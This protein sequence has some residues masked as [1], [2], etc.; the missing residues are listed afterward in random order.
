MT[1]SKKKG[2]GL[3]VTCLAFIPSCVA[4]VAFV[5]L[6]VYFG[7]SASHT[8]TKKHAHTHA[9]THTHTHAHTRTHTHTHTHLDSS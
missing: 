8:R 4:F 1:N 3:G 9:H 7:R 5:S 2:Y 6:I